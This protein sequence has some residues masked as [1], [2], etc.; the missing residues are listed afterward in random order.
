M[1][2]EYMSDELSTSFDLLR[3]AHAEDTG[4]FIS[5][6]ASAL[7]VKEA[8]LARMMGVS[9]ATLSGWRARKS[10][11]EVHLEWVSK[12]FVELVVLGRG[13]GIHGGFRHAGIEYALD[14]LRE[15]K[16]DPFNLRLEGS[17]LTELCA[18]YFEGL[19]Q[20]ALFVAHRLG[21]FPNPPLS[22]SSAWFAAVTRQVRVLLAAKPAILQSVPVSQSS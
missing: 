14:L 16:F 10:I 7:N 19:V 22:P 3:P 15:T 11:P 4:R 13:H 12:H 20:I 8:E 1:P 2:Y 18:R 21:S 6:V 17:D 5:D 9:R